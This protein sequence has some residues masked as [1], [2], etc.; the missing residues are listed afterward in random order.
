M[1]RLTRKSNGKDYCIYCSY[2]EQ[3][4]ELFGRS[5]ELV[6]PD[7]YYKEEPYKAVDGYYDEDIL[8]KLGKLEDLEEQLGCPL[9][10]VLDIIINCEP[11]YYKTNEGVELKLQPMFMSNCGIKCN[12]WYYSCNLANSMPDEFMISFKDYQ[13]TWWLKGEKPNE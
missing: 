5:E 10:V 7:E 6:T 11:I 1:N 13:K 8:V 4:N 3:T 2:I 9:E 12:Q